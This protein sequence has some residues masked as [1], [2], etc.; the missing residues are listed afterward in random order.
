MAAGA[1]APAVTAPAPAEAAG[2]Y[3]PPPQPPPLEAAV[4]SEGPSQAGGGTPA[5][6][7]AGV[8]VGPAAGSLGM[9]M[10]KKKRGRPRKYGP[11]GSL[12]MPL[13]PKP[14]S[15]SAPPSEYHPAPGM[16]RGRGRPGDFVK[17]P[18]HAVELESLGEMVACSAGANFTPHV[19][20]VAAGE[21]LDEDSVRKEMFGP[22]VLA[23]PGVPYT[24]LSRNPTP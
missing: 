21:M 2:S 22:Q 14:I 4:R 18:Q 1:A 23:H 3:Q 15:A 5:P 10:V 17:K 13:S 16:K 7:P 24:A 6:P 20:T 11:D 19:I 9:G 8:A 12:L